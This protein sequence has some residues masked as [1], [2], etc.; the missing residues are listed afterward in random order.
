LQEFDVNN[1]LDY[2][3]KKIISGGEGPVEED[4]EQAGGTEEDYISPRKMIPR[5][6]NA[7][8]MI[9]P[10]G[11]STSLVSARTDNGMEYPFRSGP[12][13][14]LHQ[15]HR[16]HQQIQFDQHIVNKEGDDFLPQNLTM[17]TNSSLSQFNKST[18]NLIYPSSILVKIEE[19]FSESD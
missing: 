13:T 7:M 15:G 12:S 14:M 5:R 4:R 16:Q 6:N 11:L 18:A 17:L 8:L 10:S 2:E 3:L 1:Q 9:D 19:S